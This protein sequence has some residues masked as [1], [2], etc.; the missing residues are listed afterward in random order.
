MAF[1]SQDQQAIVNAHN[2]YRSAQGVNTP[3]LQWDSTLAAGAQTW[4]DNLAANVH[5]IQHSPDGLAGNVGENIAS[6]STGKNTPA[7]M[8]DLWGKTVSPLPPAP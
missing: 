3:N 4:A 2:A 5:Q 1:S 8:V 6:A 7:Q